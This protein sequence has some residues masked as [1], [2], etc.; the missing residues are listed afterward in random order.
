MSDD[1]L[2]TYNREGHVGF[3]TLDRPEKRNA[4]TLALWRDLD[5][6]VVQA[7]E[8]PE[9]R[10]V[11][12]QGAGKCF[13]AGIDLSPG[14]DLFAAMIGRPG[15]AQKVNLYDEIKKGQDFH[16][17]VDRLSKPTV[18]VIHKYCLGVGLELA[19]CADIRLCSADAVFALPEVKLG[20]ITDVGGLQRLT[21]I[22]GKG[23][24][25]E[26]SFRG[27]RF[28][29][30]K[31]KAI[32]LV[33]QVY[34]DRE[35]LEKAAREMAEEIAGNP[36]LAVQGA[37]QVFLFDEEATM[38]ESLEYNAARSCMI[39]PS[40]DIGEAVSAYLEKRPGKYKGA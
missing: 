7:D 1:K 6:A 25:R 31:A 13:C 5:E 9:A 19:V 12:I 34:P 11:L 32:N 37:K 14:N 23:H 40:E 24:A 39:I 36:P 26:I 10:V 17:R 20:I 22:V 21:R 27:H 30:Q 3:I 15:A 16:T 8:D 33:N 38:D 2:V 29:A 18:A 35:T 4:V 28:D